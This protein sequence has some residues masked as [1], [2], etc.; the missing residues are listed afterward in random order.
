MKKIT[1]CLKDGLADVY[2]FATL[3][4]YFVE[5]DFPAE[6]QIAYVDKRDCGVFESLL[7]KSVEEIKFVSGDNNSDRVQDS[8]N[9]VLSAY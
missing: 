8:S 7:E 5:H 2:A 1:I 6:F 4:N 9:I 3:Y